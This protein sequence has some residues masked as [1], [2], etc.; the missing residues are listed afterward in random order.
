MPGNRVSGK[1]SNSGEPAGRIS[2]ALKR[3]F[4]TDGLRR[5]YKRQAENG[6]QYENGTSE[7]MALR[8]SQRKKK[9]DVSVVMSVYNNVDTLPAALDSILSQEGVELE[10]IVVNDGSTDGSGQILDKAAA[11]DPR[12]KVVHKQN[13]GLTQA[14][15]EGCAMASA[16]WI[17]R[18]DA[19]DLSLPGRLRA[20]LDRAL[21]LD[22]PVLIACASM[23][24]T[25]EGVEMFPAFS[26]G[27]LNKK[28]L[29]RGESPC[30][31]GAA[32][33]SK[34]AYDE[35][36]GYRPEFYYAQDLDLFTRLAKFGP[37]A[38]VP[39]TLYAYTF[40]PYSISTHASA[41]QK[42]YRELIRRGD[43]AA[44]RDA[45]ELSRKIRTGVV[46]KADPFSGYYF[47]GC[48][49]CRT[50]PQAASC[51]FRKAL[52]ARPWSVKAVLRTAQAIVAQKTE[53]RA[54]G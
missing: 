36:G 27:D 42:R 35:V 49:L 14:L 37:V 17:A 51:Y 19:D 50:N 22:D 23:Y 54:N 12:L 7:R 20:Q 30:P 6:E 52:A 3:Q 5:F 16:P 44:L 53:E 33:F 25:P 38:S 21:Q 48:C 15:I 10:V 11:R 13:E 18:Q 28:I 43:P 24:R 1:A 26:N 34:A 41:A 29:E 39:G 9:P 4:C 47:I 31:H 2:V 45:G 46:R 8:M 40:S 32:L